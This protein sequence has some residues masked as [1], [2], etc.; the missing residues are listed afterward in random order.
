MP[1]FPMI[2]I[3]GVVVVFCLWPSLSY[4]FAPSR[5]LLLH[6]NGTKSWKLEFF[7]VKNFFLLIETF[8][9][10]FSRLG[11]FLIKFLLHS[12]KRQFDVF[13]NNN[14]DQLAQILH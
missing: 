8:F 10:I 4:I 6:V 1:H 12:W 3:H 9:S 7:H 13:F 11:T 2:L 5:S 14:K